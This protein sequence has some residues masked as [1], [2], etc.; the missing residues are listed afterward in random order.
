MGKWDPVKEEPARISRDVEKDFYERFKK[1]EPG[2]YDDAEW[3][4]KVEEAD[5]KPVKKLPLCPECGC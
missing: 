2:Y 4:K 5:Q 1:H 3:W